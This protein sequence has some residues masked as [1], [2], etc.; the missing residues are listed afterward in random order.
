MIYEMDCNRILWE[1]DQRRKEM[2]SEQI[3]SLNMLCKE[4]EDKIGKKI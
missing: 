1:T 2:C 4:F 3:E